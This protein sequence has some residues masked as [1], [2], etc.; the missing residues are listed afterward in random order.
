[1][2]DEL[3]EQIG[4]VTIL[5]YGANRLRFIAP[6]RS[7]SNVRLN[8]KLLSEEQKGEGRLLTVD[9]SIDI[10]GEQKP[11]LLAEWLLYILD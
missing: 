5:N 10:Q 8:W 4:E 6:V 2:L 9:V 1:M 7:G 11:A 3:M